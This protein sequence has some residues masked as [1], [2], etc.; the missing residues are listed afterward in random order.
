MNYQNN[1]EERKR[2]RSNL[3]R[4]LKADSNDMLSTK[5]IIGVLNFIMQDMINKEEIKKQI[6]GEEENKVNNPELEQAIDKI[7][8]EIEKHREVGKELDNKI[9]ETKSFQEQIKQ[10][11]PENFEENMKDIKNAINNQGKE[12]NA[13]F[14]MNKTEAKAKETSTQHNT[15]LNIKR[16]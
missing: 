7:L 12:L 2:S 9:L 14:L 8:E 4:D 6:F 11:S 15:N 3:L 13:N 10:I 1:L 5:A 16:R